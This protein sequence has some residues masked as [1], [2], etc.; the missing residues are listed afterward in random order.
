MRSTDSGRV[1]LVDRAGLM[2]FT[3][4]AL[5]SACAAAP[6]A[7]AGV[8]VLSLDTLRADRLG[9]YGSTAGLTP[10]LDR[11]AAESV[12]FDQAYAPSNETLYSH[13][14][15]FTGQYPSRLAPLDGA[16]TLS[17]DTASL[18]SVYTA[19]GWDTA[20][21]VAGGHLSRQFGLNAG[22][23]TWDDI[24]SWGSLRDTGPKALRWL[25][26]RGEVSGAHPPDGALRPFFL[27]VHAYDTHDRY[28]RPP[29]FGYA[30]AAPEDESLGSQL[31]R[32]VGGVSQVLDGVYTAR[33]EDLEM[34]SMN[35]PR[36][37]RGRG[38]HEL[39]PA[40]RPLSAADVAL[41]NAAYDGAVAWADACFGLLLAGLDERGLLDSTVVVVLSDHGEELGERGVFQHRFS[42]TDA[43]THVPLIVRLPGGAHGGRRLTG[44]TSLV[45]VAPALLEL[46]GL[47]GL[48]GGP[49]TDGSGHALHQALLGDRY[50]GSAQVISEGGLRLMSARGPHARLTLEGV[51][52]ENPLAASILEVAPVDGV[53]L[54]LSGD[55]S[56]LPALRSALVAF[57]S[58]AA[59]P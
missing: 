9:A 30:F 50:A 10:N 29:P 2:G 5:L 23:A 22:F 6:L 55:S 43:T 54:T 17:E 7:P 48:G 41:I 25:D 26:T 16:F 58:P 56:E 47:S 51:G 49:G 38:V 27:F 39:D 52:V 13:A 53:S 14:A 28:L 3:G 36:F 4:L 35:R 24:S 18:A 11:F 20:G 34:L 40:A 33:V 15:L 1:G 32:T 42:L 31:V 12:I 44:L 59:S 21:F 57:R 45:D 46:V 8:L 37:D 19:A